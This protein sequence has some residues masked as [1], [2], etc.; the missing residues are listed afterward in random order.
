MERFEQ[1]LSVLSAAI[2]SKFSAA[3]ARIEAASAATGESQ[4]QAL[5]QIA[6]AITQIASGKSLHFGSVEGDSAGV[7]HSGSAEDDSAGVVHSGSPEGDSA[8]IVHSG[9]LEGDSAVIVHLSSAEDDSAGKAV[10]GAPSND[11]S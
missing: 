7:A 3:V 11:G 2:D 6:H 10:E 4:K 8:V 1:Q 9:S 5:L